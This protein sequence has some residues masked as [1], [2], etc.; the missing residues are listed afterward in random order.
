M[1]YHCN[2]MIYINWLRRLRILFLWFGEQ[3]DIKRDCSVRGCMWSW[4]ECGNLLKQTGTTENDYLY[5]EEQLYYLRA[6][7]MNPKMG[8]FTSMDTFAG[9]LDHLVSLHKY[10]YA[11]ANPAVS[12]YA[13]KRQCFTGDTL[14]S[15][16][17]GERRIDEISRDYLKMQERNYAK[18]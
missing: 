13:L 6:R 14:I 9:T 3:P 10:L 15:T 2:M 12:V 11:N 4:W 17:D 1:F 5:T 16:A 18:K 8:T 7:Y